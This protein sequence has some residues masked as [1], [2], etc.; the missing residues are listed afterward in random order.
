MP[1]EDFAAFSKLAGLPPLVRKQRRLEAQVVLL[2]PLSEQEKAVRKD[3]D[4][5]LVKAGIAKGDGVTCLGYDVMHVERKGN[6]TINYEKVIA[7]L[8]A[9]GVD[10]AFATKVL[11]DSSET[12][13]P[14]TWATVKPS[15]GAKVRA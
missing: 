8:V 15:K 4:A 7:Q 11:A 5:L 10:Q 13:E 1:L 14:S 12:A 9:G 2:E 6:T 3:I